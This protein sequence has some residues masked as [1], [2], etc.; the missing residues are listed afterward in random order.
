M[1]TNK[2]LKALENSQMALTLTVDAASIEEAYTAKLTKYAKDIQLKGFRKG[3]APLSVLEAKFGK[4]IREESTFDC[5]EENLKACIDTLDEKDKPLQ[6]CTP[7]LQDEESLLPFKKDE[8]ITF[9]VHYDVKP[10][11]ELPKYRDLEITYDTTEVT[12]EAVEAEITKLREQNSEVLTKDGAVEKGDIVTCNYV[13]LD[14]EG[15]EVAGT[16]RKDFTFTV[17]SS[18]NFYDMDDDIIGMT[19][20]EEKKFEKTYGE[21]FRNEDYKGKTITLLVAV[22]EIKTRQ[23]PVVDDEFAQD[24]REEYKTVDDMK[25]GIRANLQKEVDEMV[26]MAKKNAVINALLAATEFT[27][28]ASMVDFE[29]ESSWRD[30]V[31][32]SGLSEEQ[33]MNYFKA[34]GMTKES[35]TEGWREPATKNLKSQLI[36][37]AIQKA[38]DFPVD[39]A[40]LEEEFKKNIKDDADEATKEYYR[41]VLKDNMQY[42]QV[43]PFLLENNNF[44]VGKVLSRDEF[45]SQAN[46]Y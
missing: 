38:E 29:I 7:V 43:M 20:G 1:V 37:E 28:P 19:K 46:A 6:F 17:G 39:E 13:E 34:S 40:A 25:A 45:I 2:S 24:V 10:S 27:V 30:Y 35:F 14:S 3:K 42:A 16:S 15:N 5:M 21:D 4:A 26:D 23:L 22:T 18:Y 31:R 8:D 12:D 44:T 33:I 9:T 32:Q 11:F 41:N 36:L